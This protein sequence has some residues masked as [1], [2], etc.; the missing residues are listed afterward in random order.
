MTK[1]IDLLHGKIMRS[2][3]I[4]AV[5]IVMTY[6]IQMAY[7]F[8]DMIWIG[9]LGSGAVAGVGVAG[10]FTWFSN[11]LVMMAKMGGQVKIGHC[12]G[13]GD[14]DDAR[15][16][17]GAALQ[18]GIV[19]ALFFGIGINILAHSLIGFFHLSSPAVIHDAVLYLRI[20]CGLV[21]FTFMNQ[22]FTSSFNVYGDS[23][24]PFI[25]NTC[26]LVSNVIADPL[27]IF[28]IGPFPE[29][30]IRGAALA[31]GIGQTTGLCIYL[32]TSRINPLNLQ[33]K[34]Q[35][36]KPDKNICRR[37]YGIGIPATLNMALPSFL[38]S[39]LN[40]LLGTFSDTQVLVLGIYYKLQSFLY[41][42]ANGMI[43]GMRPI[44]SYNYG[45]RE[46]SRVRSIYQTAL[47]IIILILLAGTVL[48]LAVPDPLIHLFSDNTETIV[49]GRRAL[50]IICIGF[51]VSGV[52]VVTAGALEAM[53][54]GIHSL[55]ISCMRYIVLI[56]P[57][58]FIF[59][60]F[61]GVNGVWHAFWITEVIT[62]VTS[63]LIFYR[64]Y[65]A[66]A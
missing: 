11:G 41:L 32:L 27:L 21:I 53:G 47:Y 33:F 66:I 35:Y 18:L 64:Q 5:P 51:A 39:A 25:M 44:M 42:P 13:A 52:S 59:S 4:L 30:G 40:I 19:F 6:F 9:R 37:L 22:I 65:R 23:R 26:G 56:L 49:A 29:M 2:L 8:I 38:I 15:R 54:K 46:S 63:G 12:L 58:A 62:A 17:L 36:F 24:T 16:Y 1:T 48:C 28:G 55:L 10:M 45:A 34:M 7:N 3:C 57:L 43:Q 61:F 14:D 31:T 60:H 20:T 50:R